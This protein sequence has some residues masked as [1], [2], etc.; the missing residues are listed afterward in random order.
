MKKIIVEG[1]VSLQG[2]VQI[3]G[4]KNAV[5]PIMAA[6]LL[7]PDIYT[8]SR[9]PHL[10]DVRT[11]S[12]LLEVL[13]AQIENKGDTCVIDTREVNRWEAPYEIVSTMRASVC[14][15][16]PLLARFGRAKVSYPGGCV[17]GTRP[18]DLHLKGMRM[19]GAEVSMEDGYVYVE[20]SRL[21]GRRI[22]LGG[23]FGPTVLGTANVMMA[24]VKAE[25]ETVIENAACEP[26][27]VDLG[28]FL[29]K[30]G[31]DIR[32]LGG[33]TI[34]IRGVNSL[35]G[36]DYRV[37]PDR[38]EAG[39]YI[40]AGVITEGKVRVK[41]VVPAH[42]SSFLDALSSTGCKIEEGEDWVMVSREGN[43]SPL[44]ITTLPYPGFPTDLQAQMTVYLTT[45]PGISIVQER[46]FPDRFM[47]VAELLRMGAKIMREGPKAFVMGPTQLIGAPVMASDLRASAAL[48]LAGLRA[49]GKTVI[50]R[51]YHI[52]RG[53]EEIEKKLSL[54]GAKIRREEE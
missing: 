34:T 36:A 31:G 23:A 38:I 2:E 39:T 51:I 29:L 20:S 12:S 5:L 35:K 8:I 3:S 47:H 43:P 49:R 25:G 22:Y 18:I 15:L 13:G 6:T 11:M 54:L 7:Y 50:S 42:L 53:Y 16:G 48:V 4:S 17:I 33:P 19:L 40:L 21:K 14:V 52:D 28:N 32:G 27:V 44:Q 46:V 30:M 1:G 24:A 26:E 45:L 37:I 9:I 41:D 10:K